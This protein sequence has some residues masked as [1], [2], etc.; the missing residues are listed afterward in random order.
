MSTIE[1][2]R[3]ICGDGIA[4]LHAWANI[5]T[6]RNRVAL[7]AWPQQAMRIRRINISNATSWAI[8]DIMV[9]SQSP[10]H[11]MFPIVGDR[12]VGENLVNLGEIRPPG[13]IMIDVEY[14]GSD[15]A[16]EAFFCALIT[17]EPMSILPMNSAPGPLIKARGV[18]RA[19]LHLGDH[20]YRFD[21]ARRRVEI[22]TTDPDQRNDAMKLIDDMLNVDVTLADRLIRQYAVRPTRP[23]VVSLRTAE[24]GAEGCVL[25]GID[26]KTGAVVFDIW[27][28]TLGFEA[29]CNLGGYVPAWW[30]LMIT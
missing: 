8:H 13:S 16:G 27:R 30:S 11:Y 5:E 18:N 10:L 14:I 19:L 26:E 9:N 7:T 28:R 24:L 29:T 25:Y 3:A 23:V 20:V 21:E 22:T 12:L 15:P 2:L 4:Q 6:P 1:T 17:V